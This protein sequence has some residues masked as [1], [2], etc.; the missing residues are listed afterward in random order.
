[1]PKITRFEQLEGWHVA[2][3]LV[4][5]VYGVTRGFSDLEAL[6]ASF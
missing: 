4:L 3:K 1:M 6:W 5:R 2:H